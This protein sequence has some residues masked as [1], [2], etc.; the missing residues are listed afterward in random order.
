MMQCLLSEQSINIIGY[1]ANNTASKVPKERNGSSSPKTIIGSE[2]K[3]G[4]FKMKP[5]SKH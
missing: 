5:V 1:N 4:S 2:G 3:K